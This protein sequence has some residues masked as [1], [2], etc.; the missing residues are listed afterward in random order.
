M[1]SNCPYC[2]HDPIGTP[3][4]CNAILWHVCAVGPGIHD[5]NLSRF[6]RSIVDNHASKPP[7]LTAQI[8]P[9]TNNPRQSGR[10]NS[11]KTIP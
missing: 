2:G 5:D 8:P 10:K 9:H 7:K 4:P 3:Q 11:I 6:A 1:W